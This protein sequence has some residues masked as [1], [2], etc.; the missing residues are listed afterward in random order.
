MESFSNFSIRRLHR[1][2]AKVA[3]NITNASDGSCLFPPLQNIEPFAFLFRCT[4][5]TIWWGLFCIESGEHCLRFKNDRM[6]GILHVHVLFVWVRISNENREL[7]LKRLKKH[8]GL[9]KSV[10]LLKTQ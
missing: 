5:R 4:G 2:V 9:C 6:D 1:F 7:S 8:Y 10:K 3:H